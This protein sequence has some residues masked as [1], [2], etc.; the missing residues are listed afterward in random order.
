MRGF[1]AELAENAAGLVL[2]SYIVCKP[3]GNI[4]WT[5]CFDINFCINLF[6]VLLNFP[7]GL[8]FILNSSSGVL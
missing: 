6:A 8:D 7:L 4:R 2:V 3:A 1:C 5:D